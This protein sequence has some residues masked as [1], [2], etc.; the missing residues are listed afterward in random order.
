MSRIDDL[1]KEVEKRVNDKR[2]YYSQNRENEFATDCSDLI[3]K[4]LKAIG[5]DTFAATYTGNMVTELMRSNEFECLP[6]KTYTMKRGDILVKHISGN[7]GHTVLYIGD[8]MILHAKG[9]KYGLVKEQ[10]Y[11]NN[12]QYILRFKEGSAVK[13]MPTI[14]RGAKQFEVGLLQ[15][16]LNKYNKER[17]DVDCSFGPKTEQ[18]VKNFQLNYNL[19]IDGIV[20][21]QTWTKIYSIMVNA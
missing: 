18:A 1:I 5:V 2:Y 11:A 10:Y 4:S 17:L 15:L 7:N 14:R 13:T 19:E 21:P 20:G 12:Y 8:N 6:F 9:R 16:C 3:I